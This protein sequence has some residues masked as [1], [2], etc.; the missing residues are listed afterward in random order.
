MTESIISLPLFPSF[1]PSAFSNCSLSTHLRFVYTTQSMLMALAVRLI[2]MEIPTAFKVRRSIQSPLPQLPWARKRFHMV[3][4][5]G[6]K[7]SHPVKDH[8]V[9][10]R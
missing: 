4:F 6:L 9:R 3:H 5:L 8:Q 7:G 2:L 10:D 1:I